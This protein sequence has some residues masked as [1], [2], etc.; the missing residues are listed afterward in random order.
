MPDR[1]TSIVRKL[2]R[3]VNLMPASLQWLTPE[4]WVGL[5]SRVSHVRICG[6]L[7]EVLVDWR[8]CPGKT[9]SF[10]NSDEAISRLKSSKQFI[11]LAAAAHA[12]K[13]HGLVAILN[14]L[15]QLFTLALNPDVLRWVWTT[16]IRE[17][18]E[19]AFPTDAFIFELAN[20]PGNFNNH[21]IADGRLWVDLIPAVLR[22]ISVAQPTR[23][24]IVGGE[25]GFRRDVLNVQDFTNSGPAL[26]LD[27][28]YLVS[29]AHKYHIIATFHFYKPRNFTAQ[30][31][32]EVQV[33]QR[34]WLGTP[35]EMSEMSAQFDTVHRALRR[36]GMATGVPVYVGEF[37]VNIDQ[38]PFE[39]DG[40]A[41][42]RAVRLLAEERGFG[43][44]LWTY[45]SKHAVSTKAVTLGASA[46]ARLQQWDCSTHCAALFDFK[47]SKSEC[48]SR[49]ASAMMSAQWRRDSPFNRADEL[50]RRLY[51]IGHALGNVTLRNGVATRARSIS[52]RHCSDRRPTYAQRLLLLQA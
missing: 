19:K 20:E 14:P 41:W 22:L 9:R 33:P 51:G 26:S 16:M 36:P 24:M 21:S 6:S 39:T 23:V 3:G 7:A 37:G 47:R 2:G 5:K 15:H 49:N 11:G 28:P 25:M 18:D 48:P 45:Y 46:A 44:A 8:E 17:F 34:R 29:L 52:G 35:P 1:A 38:I 40:V 12:A 31:S 4:D 30:G 32:P 43:W 27:A 50:G 10:E 13:L 42:L